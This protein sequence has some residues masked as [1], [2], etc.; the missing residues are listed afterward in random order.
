MSQG[1]HF[2]K[3]GKL[4]VFIILYSLYGTSENLRLKML[5]ETITRALT[6]QPS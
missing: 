3:H 6:S 2:N 1:A 5:T 4:K